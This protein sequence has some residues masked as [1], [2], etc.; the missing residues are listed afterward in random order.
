[1]S[2]LLQGEWLS[3]VS[4]QVY[5]FTHACLQVD[6]AEVDSLLH[7]TLRFAEDNPY[8]ESTEIT[9]LVVPYDPNTPAQVSPVAWRPGQVRHCSSPIVHEISVQSYSHACAPL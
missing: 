1:M 8:L 7:I 9:R 5:S 6:V 2:H 3:M 4:E